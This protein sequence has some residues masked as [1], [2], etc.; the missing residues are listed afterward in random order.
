MNY[1]VSNVA[2]IVYQRQRK[3]LELKGLLEKENNQINNKNLDNVALIAKVQVFPM[4]HSL[5][6]TSI[7]KVQNSET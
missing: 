1:A 6:I 4:N 2:N 3:L 5:L 7:R